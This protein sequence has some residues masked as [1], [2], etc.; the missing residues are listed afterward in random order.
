MYDKAG[1]C[2]SVLVFGAAVA[3][4][5]WL[6]V[7]FLLPWA[8]PFIF[9]GTAASLLEPAV[10]K[11]VKHRWKRAAASGLLTLGVIAVLA[12]LIFILSSN[13]I[14]A[15][16]EFVKKS[17]EFM[18]SAGECFKMLE[19]R[20]LKAVSMLP[21]PVEEYIKAALSAITETFSGFP[22]IASQRLLDL[23]AKAA[24]KSPSIMLFAVT[25]GI[26]TY[27]IS[28]SFPQISGFISAQLPKSVACR[29]KEVKN[30]LKSSLGGFFRAQL[31]L[32]SMT[33]FELLVA[34]SLL[35]IKGAAAAAAITA[36]VDAL[37]VFGTG[38]ILVPWALYSFVLK[39]YTKA[40]GLVISWGLVNFIRSCAQAKLMGDEIGLSPVSSL[41][42]IYIGWKVCGV[43]GMLLFPLL[44]AVIK[45]LNSKGIIKLW[46]NV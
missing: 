42:A 46:K 27:F 9:A 4:G 37:P 23:L 41:A 30:E 14:S 12:F 35:K 10:K 15:A 39:D 26:G 22:I 38:I 21:E 33:F 6:A 16:A 8:A 44:F 28:D 13:L 3:G 11:L 36:A 45:Q 1:K 18:R 31:I 17:P 7:K 40:L 29:I 32:M 19:N 24:Q 20:L 25:A 34:F 43:W 2:F 5:I